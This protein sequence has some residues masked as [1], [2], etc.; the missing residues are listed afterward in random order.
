MIPTPIDPNNDIV[1]I[2]VDLNQSFFSF[3]NSTKTIELEKEQKTPEIQTV[4]ITLLSGLDV[5]ANY[6]MNVEFKCKVV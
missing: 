3:D 6:S 4:I 1:T 2:K 5:S